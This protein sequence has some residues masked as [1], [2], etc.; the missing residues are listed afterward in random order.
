[1]AVNYLVVRFLFAHERI[2][3]VVEGEPDV[4]V[5]HGVVQED[6]LR[7]ELLTK[8][9]LEVTAHR[10]G[11]GDLKEVEKAVIEPGGGIY[12]VARKPTPDEVEQSELIRRLDAI[13]A[14]LTD[15]RSKVERP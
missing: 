3:R 8:S 1:L 12:F 5:N 11:F 2:D 14:Q 13:A 9:E 7:R 10:Q 15:L 6:H 4:L